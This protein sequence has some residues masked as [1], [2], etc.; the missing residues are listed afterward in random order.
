MNWAPF[1]TCVIV[2]AATPGPNNLASMS[3]AG[4]IGLKKT[5]PFLFG[6]FCGLS[7]VT[8]CISVFCKTLASLLPGIIPYMKVIGAGYMLWLAWKIYK[9]GNTTEDVSIKA[10][11]I[12]G[13]LLPFANPKFILSTIVVMQV[14]VLSANFSLGGV[15]S[16]G[17]LIAVLC[18]SMNW[19]WAMLGAL[20]RKLFS[21]YA[22]VTYTIL[23]LLQAYCAVAVFM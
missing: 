6:L 13:Y 15:V 1:L 21:D 10:G 5:L 17:L 2:S 20:L 7:S 3:N 12:S 18:N 11:F 19:L 16:C 22:R 9:R 8:I 23:A 4:S 14:Y